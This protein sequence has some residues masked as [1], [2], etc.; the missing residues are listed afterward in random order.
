M[1]RIL[2]HFFNKNLILKKNI[3]LKAFIF[4]LALLWFS[5]SGFLY[6]EMTAKPDLTWSDSVWW[7]L[8]TM[9]TVGYGDYFPETTGGRFLIGMPGMIFGIGLLGFI[10]SEVAT[11]LIE[12][13]SRRLAG[14]MD[15]NFKNHIVIVNFFQLE[16]TLKLIDELKNDPT[17]RVKDIC[18]IDERLETIPVELDKLGVHFIKGN[19]TRKQIQE[20]ACIKNASHAII[21]SHNPGDPHSDDQTLSTTLMIEHINPDI[22]SIAECIDSEKIP[23]LEAAGCDSVICVSEFTTNII[24]QELQ[25]PGIKNIIN[26]ITSNTY[27]EQLYI[28]QIKKMKSWKAGSITEWASKNQYVFLGIKRGVETLLNC[29]ANFDIKDGDQAIFIG[30][31]RPAPLEL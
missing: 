23:Q 18:L 8:V 12:T 26:E 24:V 14:M 25:D 5:A 22:H 21:L 11:K 28:A 13:T 27:G 3:P 9:T 29:K 15:A 17:T 30:S 19:P 2:L 6:F 16:K 7:S 10:L 31:T 20:M 4:F 1:Y